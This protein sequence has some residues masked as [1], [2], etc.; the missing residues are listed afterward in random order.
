MI[1]TAFSGLPRR[2][3]KL[4]LACSRTYIEAAVAKQI[5][6]LLE[7]DLDWDYLLAAAQRHGVAPLLYSSLDRICRDAVPASR[8]N[9]LRNHFRANAARNLLFAAELLKLFE[10]F[11]AEKITAL[12][13][14]GP[15]LAAA[16]YGNLALRQ[17][18]DL[19]VLVKER[20]FQ[21]AKS[22]LLA[23]GYRPWR[24]LTP[25]QEADHLQSN[26]AYT[27][28]SAEEH[29]R[30]DLH[31]RIAQSR[32]S[33]AL[34]AETL[35]RRRMC[36][37]FSRGSLPSLPPEDLLL[38]LCIHGSKHCWERLAWICDIA[39]LA[40][41]NPALDWDEMIKRAAA[42]NSE[43][44]VLLGL[45]LAQALLDAPLPQSILSKT[46]GERR[47]KFLSSFVRRQL[48]SR[49]HKPLGL[50]AKTALY[51][52]MRERPRNK[53]PYLLFSLR[54]ALTPTK[55]DT[56]VLR[57]PAC[58]HFLYYPLR[59]VRLTSR[60]ISETGRRLLALQVKR[61][62]VSSEESVP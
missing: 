35:W 5:K 8:M 62:R 45:H 37:P 4:L 3:A 47:I 15:V 9:A 48:F 11:E 30:L 46:A 20:D 34:D 14:K 53:L 32:Y 12:P 38:I 58:L 57:L 13:I 56:S 21:K 31:W 19:D 61:K 41:A 16:A 25:A 42:L 43:R 50:L 28:I 59:L 23:Q 36:V 39:E 7:G 40:R 55:N 6:S 26:H 54:T 51:V 18:V 17:F 2:E 22:M 52:S 33:F 29:V 60:S 27:L 49:E 1:P 10:L 44:A 24:E